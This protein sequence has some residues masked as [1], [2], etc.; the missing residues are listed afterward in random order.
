MGN[1]VHYYGIGEA[2][3]SGSS[4]AT[5]KPLEEEFAKKKIEEIA[6]PF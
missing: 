4:Y 5:V 6:S 1:S 3:M 2:A